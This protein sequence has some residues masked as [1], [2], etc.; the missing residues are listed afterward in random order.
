M[1]KIKEKD[2]LTITGSLG[3]IGSYLIHNKDFIK[4]FK[5]IYLI[6]N[7]SAERFV[8]LFNLPKYGNFSFFNIDL[9]NQSLRKIIKKSDI[10]LHLAATTN[11]EASVNLKGQQKIKN[12]LST[13]EVANL[14][15]EYNK[16]L[17]FISSTSVYGSSKGVV[18]ES[19]RQ[20]DINPQSPYAV[21][22]LKEEYYFREL[23][24][25]HNYNNFVIL[26]FGTIF[27]YSI[28]I[29]FHTA[30]NKFCFQAAT[31][32]PITVWKTAKNQKRPYLSL[33]DACR[34]LIFITKNKMFNGEIYNILTNN[35][36]VNDILN[37]I[38]KDKKIKVKLVNSRIMN[39]LS[40]NVSNEKI[41]S[42]GFSFIGSLKKEISNTLKRLSGLDL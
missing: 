34:A 39:Q 2:N 13:V 6:D 11:A 14:C 32:L 26:R 3:H 24:N 35:Y 18:D 12:F 9:P 5:K 31:K 42:N 27:G 28:G 20:S 22:K 16:K 30:V 41:K 17:I 19:C 38:K 1:L 4:C 15:R 40:F 23:Q 7:L 25:K 10:V 37:V 33:V 36:T 8:S 29:R 21:S